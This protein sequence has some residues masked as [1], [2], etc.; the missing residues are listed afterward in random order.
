MCLITLDSEIKF[1]KQDIPVVK[2]CRSIGSDRCL[3][4]FYDFEY[5]YGKIY[6]DSLGIHQSQLKANGSFEV[7]FP[8]DSIVSM[9][10]PP[11]QRKGKSH[12]MVEN[13]F[14]SMKKSRMAE[15]IVKLG[16]NPC[17]FVQ[18]IIPEGAAY[19]EDRTGLYVSTE[20][21]IN[22]KL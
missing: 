7:G 1:A 12:T 14:H 11:C 19:M 13:G 15:S 3:S 22:G 5:E 16:E 6:T 17:D 8:Y 4:I 10:Y 9:A 21:I 18:G 20:I 2:K